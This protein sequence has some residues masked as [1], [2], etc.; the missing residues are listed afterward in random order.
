VF[1]RDELVTLAEEAGLDGEQARAVL[2][3]EAFADAVRADEA[4]ARA[5]R[6]AERADSYSKD[7]LQAELSGA[8]ASL[9][10]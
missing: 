6:E 3:S 5:K 9:K 10:G 8:C 1:D 4:Q 2:G 7:R